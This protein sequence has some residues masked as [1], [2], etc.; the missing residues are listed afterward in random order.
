VNHSINPAISDAISIQMTFT[1]E[2]LG[3]KSSNQANF[4]KYFNHRRLSNYWIRAV[5]YPILS[6]LAAVK[7]PE[8]MFRSNPDGATN[9]DL[10]SLLWTGLL[11]KLCDLPMIT[12][13]TIP[14]HS[15]VFRIYRLPLNI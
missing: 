8:G 1:P 12:V 10:I 4:L 5:H 7:I 6:I 14:F 15:D 11:H 2:E 3:I 9:K 13:D